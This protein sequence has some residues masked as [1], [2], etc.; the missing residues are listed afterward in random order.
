MD[1]EIKIPTVLVQ[2]RSDFIRR[3]FPINLTFHSKVMASFVYP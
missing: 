3:N 1:V 2:H